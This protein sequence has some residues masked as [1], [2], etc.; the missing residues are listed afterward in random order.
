M[1]VTVPP[2]KMP[3]LQAYR[4]EEC[5]V[6]YDYLHMTS[7]DVA[8]C[9]ACSSVKSDLQLGGKSLYKIIP[10]Y[11]NSK[12]LRAGYVHSHGDRPAEKISSQVPRGPKT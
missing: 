6:A 11:P 12:R 10:V 9:P 4:C 5:G 8:M 3:K 2:T 1:S 7:D